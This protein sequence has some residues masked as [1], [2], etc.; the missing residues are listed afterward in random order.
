MS[1][2][3]APKGS[4]AKILDLITRALDLAAVA[5]RHFPIYL[6]GFAMT[7]AV[8]LGRGLV[9]WLAH[10]HTSE[11]AFVHAVPRRKN[12][13]SYNKNAARVLKGLG[14]TAWRFCTLQLVL[15]SAL[16]R[17][18]I[19][20]ESLRWIS[21]TQAVFI[22]YQ[23]LQNFRR[24]ALRSASLD[25]FGRARSACLSPRGPDPAGAVQGGERYKFKHEQYG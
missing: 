13:A 14:Q 23:K 12:L 4:K 22:W 15:P 10:E 11:E 1:K 5:T 21:T 9:C 2:P 8:K 20:D 17:S 24:D 3:S 25:S 7:E 18:I 16:G 19:Y 6:V